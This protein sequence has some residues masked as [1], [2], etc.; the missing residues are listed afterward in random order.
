MAHL[1]PSQIAH[2]SIQMLEIRLLNA[3]A[4]NR[5][6]AEELEEANEKITRLKD[7][8]NHILNRDVNEYIQKLE[9]EIR[10][11]N[12]QNTQLEMRIQEIQ[13][14]GVRMLD[15]IQNNRIQDLQREIRNIRRNWGL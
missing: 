9:R 6:L 5:A 15:Y 13:A 12:T 11:L 10:D 1:N 14:A 7:F 2:Q 8:L 3:E 4:R